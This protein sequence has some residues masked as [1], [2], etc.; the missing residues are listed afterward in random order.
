MPLERIHRLEG[1]LPGSRDWEAIRGAAEAENSRSGKYRLSRR[2]TSV[3]SGAKM[4]LGSPNRLLALRLVPGFDRIRYVAALIIAQPG[5]A[6]VARRVVGLA[7]I[8]TGRADQ[9]DPR[10]DRMIVVDRPVVGHASFDQKIEEDLRQAHGMVDVGVRR[11]EHGEQLGDRFAVGARFPAPERFRTIAALFPE[12][13]AAATGTDHDRPYA[14]CS[15]T[16]LKIA[17]VTLGAAAAAMA[18]QKEN[19]PI[20]VLPGALPEAP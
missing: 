20:V 1:A 7:A 18:D 10:A 14:F 12:E 15:E 6:R 19:R 5:Q 11:V 9:V 2:A 4:R 13:P 16:V 8:A 17:K 3:H